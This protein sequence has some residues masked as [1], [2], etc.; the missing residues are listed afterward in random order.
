MAFGAGTDP[1][2][3]MPADVEKRPQRVTRV[4]RNNDAFT[5]NLSQ[6]K[7]ARCRDLVCA[8]GADPGLAVEAFEFIAEEIGIG[9]VAGR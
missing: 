4:P 5:R 2:A 9:V 6:K 7:V 3:A 1:G 8:P